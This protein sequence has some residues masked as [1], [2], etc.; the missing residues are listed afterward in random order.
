MSSISTPVSA[1]VITSSIALPRAKAGDRASRTTDVTQ[2]TPSASAP[3]ATQQPPGPDAL[4]KLVDTM[5]TKAK[6]AG[7]DLQFSIDQESGRSIVRVT[8]RSSKDVI[9]QF[10]SEEALQVTKE[11]DR[12]QSM[13]SRKA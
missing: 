8:E 5:Q 6:S 9:W 4:Q 7:S 12:F 3:A 10:P 1:P 13:L 2:A 11:L